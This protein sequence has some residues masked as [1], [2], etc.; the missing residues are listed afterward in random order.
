M[1]NSLPSTQLMPHAQEAHHNASAGNRA[2]VTLMAAMYSTTRPLTMLNACSLC[3]VRQV[4][5]S[6]FLGLMVENSTSA[7][8]GPKLVHCHWPDDFGVPSQGTARQPEMLSRH[9]TSE[10]KITKSGDISFQL[11]VWSSGMILAQGARGPG[12]NSQNSPLSP[13]GPGHCVP[14]KKLGQV[15]AMKGSPGASLSDTAGRLQLKKRG[16]H[17]LPPPCRDG[18]DGLPHQNKQ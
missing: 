10:T 3:T 7:R 16:S 5:Q 2:R 11:A 13:W 15:M 9:V 8:S 12:L 14:L 4:T 18:S 17:G 6:K 1:Q